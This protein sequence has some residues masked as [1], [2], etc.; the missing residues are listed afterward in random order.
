MSETYTQGC[1]FDLIC[2]RSGKF[3]NKKGSP[4]LH[5]GGLDCGEW[6]RLTDDS[7]GW[8]DPLPNRSWSND[9][10]RHFYGYS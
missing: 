4:C 8:N 6:R 2:K 1:K 9:G 7:I 10:R 3:S 5:N